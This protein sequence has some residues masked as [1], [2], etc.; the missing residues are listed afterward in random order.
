MENL[1]VIVGAAECKRVTIGETEYKLAPLGPF[2]V[3]QL[4]GYLKDRRR[5]EVA[6][7]A[8][9]MGGIPL[10]E[11]VE[12]TNTELEKIT[13][14]SLDTMTDDIEAMTR[15]IFFSMRVYQPSLLYSDMGK[16]LTTDNI[17]KVTEVLMSDFTEKENRQTVETQAV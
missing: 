14:D 5:S 16:I 1:D 15:M 2:V 9:A 11:L 7:S 6:A 4:I 13:I 3:G 8:K 12:N 17:V 10:K